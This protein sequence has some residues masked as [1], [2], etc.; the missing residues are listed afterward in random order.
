MFLP[1]YHYYLINYITDANGCTVA[2]QAVTITVNPPLAVIASADNAICEGQST[3][4]SAVASGGNG[5]PLFLFWDNNAGN[6]SSA[7]ISPVQT[8]TYTVTVNDNCGTP[9]ATDVVTI[10]VNPLPQV[11]YIPEPPTGCVPLEVNFIDNS[12]TANGSQYQWSFGDG[13]HDSLSTNPVH[14]YY[15]PGTYTV[16]LILPPLWLFKYAYYSQR[17]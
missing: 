16:S 12:V 17:G 5:G 10:V 1:V 8:T 2:Q 11:N 9:V 6:N 15:E 13:S 3:T 4:I 14:I 7:T